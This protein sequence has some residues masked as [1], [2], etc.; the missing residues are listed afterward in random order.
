VIYV[1]GY[2]TVQ[3]AGGE[4]ESWTVKLFNRLAMDLE[5]TG[6]AKTARS[7][8]S[9][10]TAYYDTADIVGTVYHTP[11]LEARLANYPAY[12]SLAE[13]PEFQALADDASFTDLRRKQSAL[14]TILDH[15]RAQAI[16]KNPD[17]LKAI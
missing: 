15:P 16:V 12:L 4:S 1:F 5:S 6:M 3:I 2:W 7:L 14:M 11:Q 9:L 13:R 17:L 10:P 8:E